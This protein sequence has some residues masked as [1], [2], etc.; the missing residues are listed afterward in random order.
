MCV[1]LAETFSSY[2]HIQTSKYKFLEFKCHYVISV[3]KTGIINKE[4][5]AGVVAGRNWKGGGLI[6]GAKTKWKMELEALAV[7]CPSFHLR[8]APDPP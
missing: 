3:S 4:L 6:G 2:T 1:I 7:I 5:A 8:H